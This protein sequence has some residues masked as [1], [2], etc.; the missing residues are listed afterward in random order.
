MRPITVV[1]ADGLLVRLFAADG[2][3]GTL[4]AEDGSI[5]WNYPLR[6]MSLDDGQCRSM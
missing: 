2:L 5:K 3:L 6:P 4:K 1:G